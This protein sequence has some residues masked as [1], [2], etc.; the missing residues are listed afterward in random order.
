V[1]LIG[2]AL[3]A[4]LGARLLPF[5]GVYRHRSGG[6]SGDTAAGGFGRIRAPRFDHTQQR[7]LLTKALPLA[8]ALVLGHVYVRLVILC[9]GTRLRGLHVDEFLFFVAEDFELA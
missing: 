2:V 1:T 6:A 4:A 5:F 3:L 7:A 8:A 9:P